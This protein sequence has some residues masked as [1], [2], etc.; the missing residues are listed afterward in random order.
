MRSIPETM[1]WEIFRRGRWHLL[2]A[3]LGAIALPAVVFT[4]LRLDGGDFKDPSMLMMHILFVNNMILIFGA[5]LFAAQGPISQLYAYPLR[6]SSIVAWRM[7]PAMLIIGALTAASIECLNLSFELTWPIWGPAMFASVAMATVSAFAWLFEKSP[8]WLGITMGIVAAVL[9]FWFKSRYG[10]AFSNATHYWQQVRPVDAFAMLA[11][12]LFAYWVA[13]KAVSRNRRG[14]PA[15][16]LGWLEWLDRVLDCQRA[17][18]AQLNS[19]FHAQCWF[20]WRRKGW[21]MPAG[22]I[23]CLIIGLIVWALSDRQA[24]TLVQGFFGGAVILS[25]LG[26]IS[27]LAFGNM[28]PNDASYDM[29]QFLATRPTT[30]TDTA[31][32]IFLTAA[33]SVIL[34][35]AI[36]ALAFAVACGCIATIG[37]ST[38]IHFPKD[39]IGWWYFPATFIGSWVIT[40]NITCLLLFGRSKFVLQLLCGLAATI[41][42]VSVS[43][44]FLLR[45]AAH[46]L[47]IQT[48][49]ALL[50]SG[51]VVG[52]ALA[53]VA[54]WR[55][56]L[57]QWATTWIAGCMWIA[58]T[59]LSAIF[60]PTYV[61]PRLLAYLLVASLVTLLVTPVAAA[62]LGISI[63]RHR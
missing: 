47:L 45:P 54:A 57:I 14:E 8:I 4:A 12:S 35:W 48:L 28:G 5:A 32:A 17:F 2:S 37:S 22:T 38:A 33:K 27:G 42:I 25:M 55:R 29:G 58:A 21:I 53:F 6:T 60:L 3:T 30:D 51:L 26:F 31:R 62:P 1:T 24:E 18:G 41:M 46:D 63:N 44:K 56:R 9:G 7:M 50:A 16:S 49:T 39:A 52:G 13:V 43:S 20:Q 40:S 34:A 10:S 61:Q 59:V 11:M 23:F 19:P 36:W 15:F